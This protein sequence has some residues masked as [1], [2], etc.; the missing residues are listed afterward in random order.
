MEVAMKYRGIC[1]VLAV[2][3]SEY[4]RKHWSLLMGSREFRDSVAGKGDVIRD[5]HE[6]G[7]MN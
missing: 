5:V 6:L 2:R 3:G 7:G 1:D 4:V